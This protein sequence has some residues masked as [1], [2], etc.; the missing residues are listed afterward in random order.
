MQAFSF[1]PTR[2]LAPPLFQYCSNL[3]WSFLQNTPAS[4]MR[5]AGSLATSVARDR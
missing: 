2:P 4:I 1:A 3:F 5:L